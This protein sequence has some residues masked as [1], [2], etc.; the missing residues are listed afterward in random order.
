MTTTKDTIE[1]SG[2]TVCSDFLAD[3]IN[4]RLAELREKVALCRHFVNKWRNQTYWDESKNSQHKRVRFIREQMR[5]TRIAEQAL[6][7]FIAEHRSLMGPEW[8]GNDHGR[9][10]WGWFL[11]GRPIDQHYCTQPEGHTGFCQDD[12]GSWPKGVHFDREW[13]ERRKGCKHREM[14]DYNGQ[15]ACVR[16]GMIFEAE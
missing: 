7:D 12:K 11:G 16:C 1:R 6:K 2:S 10:C 15:V 3:A 14:A 8:I 9:L 5:E 13:W 4:S